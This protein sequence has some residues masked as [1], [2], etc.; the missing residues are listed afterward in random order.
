MIQT[1]CPQQY[2]KNQMNAG[3]QLNAIR[4]RRVN[5]GGIV[6]FE[7]RLGFHPGTIATRHR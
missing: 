5:I 2:T 1:S 4:V 7:L 6:N 3:W